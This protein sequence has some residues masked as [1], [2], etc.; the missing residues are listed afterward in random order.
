MVRRQPTAGQRVA[1]PCERAR[2]YR[3]GVAI[4]RFG[5]FELDDEAGELRR[6]GRLIRLTGQ[7]LAALKRL[8]A[9]PGRIVTRDELRR[10]IWGD[11]RFVDFD[12]NLNFTIAAVRDALGDSARNP[13]FIE[14]IPRRG[15]RFI[16]DVAR[17]AEARGDAAATSG[18]RAAHRL[19]LA[20][21]A[22]IV[23]LIQTPAPQGAH[24]R[25]TA[26][27]DALSAFEQGQTEASE[28]L[29]GRRRSV[30]RFR[31]AARLDP[32]F[33]E[34]HYAL[35]D[36][37]LD[38]ARQRLLPAA[39]AL[40]EARDAAL[41][42]VALEEVADTRRVLGDVRLLRDWDWNGARREL[43]RSI[44]MAPASDMA[45]T[46]YARFLSAAG[47][48]AR[49][50]DTID[51]AE[52]L[53]PICDLVLWESALIRY[54]AHRGAEAIQKI[55]LAEE[56][57]PPGGADAADWHVRLA[58]LTFLVRVDE[59]A[60]DLAA[61]AASEIAGVPTE[62]SEAAVRLF[63][64]HAAD[65]EARLARTADGP[66]RTATLYAVAGDANASLMWLER[67]LD[68]RDPALPFGLRNPAFDGLRGSTRFVR[69][70]LA[71]RFPGSA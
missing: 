13:R 57:G 24:T 15:Y 67:A 21:A 46:E 68:A 11:S 65:R 50:I 30:Y 16:A 19:P 3:V 17:V 28:G 45:L 10:H 7:P 56:F 22:I 33:A 9:S 18:A 41:R 34:A 53:S 2:W 69:I 43:A 26:A 62:A 38:L 66:V 36:I 35:A 27:A 4:V 39:A 48:H 71:I 8:V 5:V 23:A 54:R 1:S 31:E 42:A 40:T 47:E 20:I 25:T 61:A 32:R 6:Q 64:R 49:A 12:R 14:T 44:E 60:W 70:A 58:W 63:A 52:T 37:Y 55:R 59:R 51:R 29:D